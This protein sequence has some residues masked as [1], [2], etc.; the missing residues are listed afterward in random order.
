MKTKM[1]ITRWKR[2]ELRWM[3]IWS[4]KGLVQIHPCK[5]PQQNRKCRGWLLVL[6]LLGWVIWSF[7]KLRWKRIQASRQLLRHLLIG[8]GSLGLRRGSCGD[9]TFV[10]TKAASGQMGQERQ[11][12]R[13]MEL[14]QCN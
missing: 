12:G 4:C 3:R 9:R 5:P 7:C 6:T 11:Y 14:I 8:R 13:T 2:R 1:C 10:K